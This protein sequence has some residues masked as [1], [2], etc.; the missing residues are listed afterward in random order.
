[1]QASLVSAR[2]NISHLEACDGNVFVHEELNDTRLVQILDDQ[3]L[4]H[5][6]TAVSLSRFE[7]RFFERDVC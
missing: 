4:H 1:M 7:P 5:L 2:V 3:A 6:V